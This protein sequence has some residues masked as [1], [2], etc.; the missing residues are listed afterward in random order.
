MASNESGRIRKRP[1]RLRQSLSASGQR[2]ENS[3]DAS[4]WPLRKSTLPNTQHLPTKQSKLSRHAHIPTPIG[5]NL[6]PPRRCVALGNQGA[7]AVMT[8]PK[9][10]INKNCQPDLGE[11][12]VR[13]TRQRTISAPTLDS[14]HPHEPQELH[15]RCCV[16]RTPNARHQ[17]RAGKAAKC[18][19]S[20][21]A[22]AGPL[23]HG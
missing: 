6:F 12:K 7:P 15:F 4:I 9:A 3:L 17:F 1:R 16:S 13:L 11:Y 20:F 22:A 21:F 23:A 14:C 2:S 18:S 10:T 8:M 19:L 5:E